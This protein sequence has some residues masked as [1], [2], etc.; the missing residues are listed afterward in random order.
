MRWSSRAV[1]RR[2]ARLS[3]RGNSIGLINLFA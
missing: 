3:P 2:T 1:P